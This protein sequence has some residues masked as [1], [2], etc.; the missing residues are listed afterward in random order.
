MMDS[1]SLTDF[2]SGE[3]QFLIEVLLNS[4]EGIFFNNVFLK[5][6]LSNYRTPLV[7]KNYICRLQMQKSNFKT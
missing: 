5:L 4:G 2:H 7:L 1:I 3:A 6:I